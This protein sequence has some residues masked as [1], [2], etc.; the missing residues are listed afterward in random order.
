M[1]MP[2]SEVKN[3]LLIH[4]NIQLNNLIISQNKTVTIY[5]WY[6]KHKTGKNLKQHMYLVHDC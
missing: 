6:K 5:D 3:N 2:D 1:S 4:V